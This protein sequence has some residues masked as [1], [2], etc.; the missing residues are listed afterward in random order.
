MSSS[1]LYAFAADGE[2]YPCQNP[3]NTLVCQALLD[4]SETYPDSGTDHYR[5]KN[6]REA[7]ETLTVLGQNIPAVCASGDTTRITDEVCRFFGDRTAQFILDFCHENP[8]PAAKRASIHQQMHDAPKCTHKD[9]QPLYDALVKK[10]ASYPP[11]KKYNKQA[12]LSAAAAVLDLD[13]SLPALEWNDIFSYYSVAS[14]I[15]YTGPKTFKFIK[16]FY[17]TERPVRCAA[18]QRI[19]ETIKDA[20]YLT[21]AC[22]ENLALSIACLA[23]TLTKETVATAL[24]NHFPMIWAVVAA[25][26]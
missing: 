4:K 9:N 5:R 7:A 20:T 21:T 6:Y 13:Y 3:A 16:D 24:P 22:R 18:N 2:V 14:K 25:A 12:Y 10:A 17:T 15:P 1:K 23:Q 26:L 11:E 8:A 19:Y